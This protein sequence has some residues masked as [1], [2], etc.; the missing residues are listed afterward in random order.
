[1]K[2]EIKDSDGE[3]KEFDSVDEAVNYCCEELGDC[4]QCPGRFDCSEYLQYGI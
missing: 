1:M 3:I 2:I 4:H